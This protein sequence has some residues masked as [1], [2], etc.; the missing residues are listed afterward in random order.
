MVHQQIVTFLF[1]LLQQHIHNVHISVPKMKEDDG[2]VVISPK[3][4]SKMLSVKCKREEAMLSLSLSLSLSLL[5]SLNL[6]LFL[7]SF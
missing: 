5:L 7:C 6:L 4:M 3:V 2:Q 1:E